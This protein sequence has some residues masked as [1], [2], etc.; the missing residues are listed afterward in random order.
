L[1]A[2]LLSYYRII[3]LEDVLEALLQEQI[4]D[5]SDKYE[6]DAL[7]VARWVAQKWKAYV[8]RGKRQ[9]ALVGDESSAVPNL[10]M[11]S[12]V[13]QAMEHQHQQANEQSRLLGGSNEAAVFDPIGGMMQFFDNLSNK[14]E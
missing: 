7:R 2:I 14:K 3:T 10:S 1:F 9:R 6:R 5:E 11:G 4:Y 12:V 8:R 13:E